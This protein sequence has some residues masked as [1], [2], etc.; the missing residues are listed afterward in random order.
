MPEVRGPSFS[1]DRGIDSITH[2]SKAAA[3][4]LGA[5]PER[6]EAPPADLN[7]RP[8]L[9]QLLHQPSMNDQLQAQ[10]RPQLEHRDLLTPARFREVLGEAQSHLRD[11]ADVLL[12]QGPAQADAARS[13]NRAAR[14]LQEE[15][16]LRELLQTY[17]SALFQG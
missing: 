11:S 10:L 13:L 15:S 17:R 9:D 6:A 8:Q 14:L 2:A 3:G 4:G 1:F 12:Q 7:N 5:M 16:Q